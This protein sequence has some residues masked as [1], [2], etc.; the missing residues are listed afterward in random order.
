MFSH[1]GST[2]EIVINVRSK[3]LVTYD[4]VRYVRV[5]KSDHC[6]NDGLL[7]GRR[8]QNRGAFVNNFMYGLHKV[9]T[10][11]SCIQVPFVWYPIKEI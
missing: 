5:V 9:F 2:D 7:L 10:L 6:S 1:R 3:R 4:H 8:T 11:T